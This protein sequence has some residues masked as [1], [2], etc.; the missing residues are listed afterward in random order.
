MLLLSARQLH[1][2]LSLRGE[3]MALHV[4]GRFPKQSRVVSKHSQCGVTAVAQQ[5]SRF[6]GFVIVV[7]RGS[8]RF[9]LAFA[10]F[11][12]PVL[13]FEHRLKIDQTQPI[14]GPKRVFSVRSP[15]FEA[16][17]FDLGV[18]T[19]LASVAGIPV[20]LALFFPFFAKFATAF[21]AV[22]TVDHAG[23]ITAT[24]RLRSFGSRSEWLQ[25]RRSKFTLFAGILHHLLL[26]LE[27]APAVFSLP[28]GHQR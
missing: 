1:H 19:K 24:Q 11:A 28:A 13:G 27:L 4:P 22:A 10:Q 25:P 18:A 3:S 6:A 26:A 21:R 14:P 8:V 2:L 17:R 16:L 5:A 12:A 20:E 9:Q 15:T 23:I 7:Y